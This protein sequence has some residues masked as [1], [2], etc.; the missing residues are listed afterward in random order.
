MNTMTRR[1]LITAA[2]TA[3]CIMQPV[4]AGFVPDVISYE[5]TVLD[6]FGQ[7]ATGKP[8]LR[9]S[10][11]STNGAVQ[12]TERHVQVPLTSSGAF[13][14]LLGKTE[15]LPEQVDDLQLLVELN[16]GGSSWKELTPP[17]MLP[18]VVY[19]LQ[20]EEARRAPGNLT[21]KQDL[22]V[23]GRLTALE[24]LSVTQVT[25][26]VI[27]AGSIDAKQLIAS[28][29]SG[30]PGTATQI[31][32][33]LELTGGM[34]VKGAVAMMK[35]INLLTDAMPSTLSGRIYLLADPQTGG[36]GEFIVD[37]V[38]LKYAAGGA[39]SIYR[40][41]M[42]VGAFF[43]PLEVHPGDSIEFFFSETDKTLQPASYPDAFKTLQLITIGQ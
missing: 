7:P 21:V 39:A 28:D 2:L 8:T 12:W 6:E 17:Q 35:V 1:F 22:Y 34:V 31:D 25:A 37:S 23:S 19:A 15:P 36:S 32:C 20:A 10:L 4:H 16:T 3:L 30:R 5:G 11:L 42:P 24:T 43:L 33:A 26:A 29:L 9:F 41:N 13:H 27:E 40:S 14:V 18:S 38:R